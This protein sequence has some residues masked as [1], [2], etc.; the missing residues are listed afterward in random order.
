MRLG[1]EQNYMGMLS[2]LCLSRNLVIFSQWE[3]SRHRG[4]EEKLRIKNT[5]SQ[6][7]RVNTSIYRSK[8]KF[9]EKGWRGELGIHPSADGI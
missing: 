8:A 5:D 6:F 1:R 4:G 2:L 9:S 7:G 3:K